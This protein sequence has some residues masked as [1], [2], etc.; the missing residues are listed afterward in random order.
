M[1]VDNVIQNYRRRFG[2]FCNHSS[3]ASVIFFH[4][5][6]DSSQIGEGVARFALP[7]RCAPQLCLR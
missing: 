3:F 5:N 6:F 4:G 1:S 7:W 2:G